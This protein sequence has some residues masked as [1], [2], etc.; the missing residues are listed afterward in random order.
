MYIDTMFNDGGYV[1][2][3]SDDSF[4]KFTLKSVGLDLKAR[5]GLSKGK[6][7]NGF[8]SDNTI[9][10][11]TKMKLLKDLLD[12]YEVFRVK[13]FRF[14]F[15]KIDDPAMETMIKHNKQNCIN[16]LNKYFG[17]VISTDTDIVQEKGLKDLIDEAKHIIKKTKR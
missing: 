15:K 17:V 9:N 13:S 2:D 16:I 8:F 11:K 6:S 7:L 10:I 4:A 14:G 3:F 1:L 5:Y 12:Y